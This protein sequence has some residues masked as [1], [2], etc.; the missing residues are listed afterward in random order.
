MEIP[1][2]EEK[3]SGTVGE[4]TIGATKEEGGTREKV[5]KV[6]GAGCVP[7]MDFEGSLGNRPVIAMDVLDMPPE[8]WPEPLME[9]FKDVLTDPARW[10]EKCVK[11]FGA[12]LICLKLN[13]VHPD[14]GNRSPDDAAKTVRSV[15]EAVGVPLIIWGCDD[16]NKDNEVMPKVSEAAKGERCLLSGATQDNYKT[17]TAVCM[18]DGHNLVTQAPVD[19]NIQKQ[20]NILVTDIGFPMDR[21]VMFQT[22]GAL[23]YGMEYVY[24]IQERERLAALSGDKWLALPVLT[25]VGH[26]SW[27]AKEA[28]AGDKEAPGWG[29]ARER[30]PLWEAVTAITLLQSGVDII[31]MLHPTAVKSVKKYIDDLYSNNA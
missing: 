13:S 11:E 25:N 20:V 19:V 31:R 5:V 9:H 8:E 30:G 17:I 26:E 28:K 6:G 10:A 18:A 23:G 27:R 15:L 16:P 4:A 21:I 29:L 2:V 22:T 24:S 12:D 7:Y 3:W 1:S 14:K